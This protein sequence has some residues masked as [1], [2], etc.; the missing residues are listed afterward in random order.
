[1]SDDELGQHTYYRDEA[2][3]DAARLA[4]T[5]PGPRFDVT[6]PPSVLTSWWYEMRR[7]VQALL[8]VIDAGVNPATVHRDVFGVDPAA[9]ACAL[10]HV[11]EDG[12][13]ECVD[14]DSIIEDAARAYLDFLRS[15]DPTLTEDDLEHQATI[16]GSISDLELANELVRVAGYERLYAVLRAQAGRLPG[17]LDAGDDCLA[18]TAS[19]AV[20]RGKCVAAGP[21]LADIVVLADN[22]QEFNQRFADEAQALLDGGD[23]LAAHCPPGPDGRCEW[24]RCAERPPGAPGEAAG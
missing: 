8:A 3:I 24:P 13:G 11:R 5:L 15:R 21:H 23:C 22:G 6:L 4:A 10:D 16:R 19:G 1:M 14:D 17:E 2:A 20:F 12:F 7:Q 18:V 9:L